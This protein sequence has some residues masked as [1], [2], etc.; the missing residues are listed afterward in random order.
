MS[1]RV[2]VIEDQREI[3]NLVKLHLHDID[4]QVK[5]AFDGSAGLADAEANHYDLIILDLML[6]RRKRFGNLPSPPSPSG[7]HAHSDVDVARLG[8]RSCPGP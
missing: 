2:L 5:L 7:L 4:C 8:T 1:Y 6:P 3:A